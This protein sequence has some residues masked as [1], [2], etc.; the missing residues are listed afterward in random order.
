MTKKTRNKSQRPRQNDQRKQRP[1]RSGRPEP[2][3]R[4][5]PSRRNADKAPQAKPDYK[6]DELI[7]LNK[8]IA[9][10]GFC[11][12]RDADELIAAGSVE[13]NGEVVTELGTKVQRKD[14]VAVDGQHLTLE[15]FVYILLNKPKDTISTTDDERDRTTVMDKVQ[16]ATGKRVYPVGR[17]DR[18]TMGLLL[19][20][21]DGDLANRLMHPSY[22]VR[23]TYEVQ[24]ERALTDDELEQLANGINLQDGMAQGY[25]IT[26]APD[27]RRT[28]GLS[29]FEG[30]NRLVRRMMEYF[31]TEV[32]KLKRIG[33]AGLTLKDVNLGRWRY[34][35]QGEVNALRKLVKLQPLDFNKQ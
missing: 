20:T 13:V 27:D 1:K 31:G 22:Q 8:F 7:R 15:D 14:E 19:L 26:R 35:K 25:R 21:N 17:L 12:R 33:Y 32:T 24:T 30:R 2:Q 10:A 11:S 5:K 16:D 6:Q 4:N 34:L 3:G 18:D 29:V 9:H 23:K 28:I